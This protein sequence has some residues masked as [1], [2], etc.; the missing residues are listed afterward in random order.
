MTPSG[1][2]HVEEAAGGLLTQC[3]PDDDALGRCARIGAHGRVAVALVILTMTPSR[4][5]ALARSPDR[6]ITTSGGTPGP[7][8]GSATD[9]AHLRAATSPGA[10]D[11]AGPEPGPGDTPMA[12]AFALLILAFA[13]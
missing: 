3:D 11:H 1:V 2:E 13:V 12:S 5:S 6:L 4:Q 8:T 9:P 10:G 7:A